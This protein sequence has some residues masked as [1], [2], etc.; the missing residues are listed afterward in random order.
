MR[1]VFLFTV[2]SMLVACA[3]APKYMMAPPDSIEAKIKIATQWVAH[4]GEKYQR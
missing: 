3:S 4:A 2:L 1:S